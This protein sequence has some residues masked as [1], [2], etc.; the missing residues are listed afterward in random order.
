MDARYRG[1]CGNENP[2]TNGILVVFRGETVVYSKWCVVGCEERRSGGG[3]A[4]A[5]V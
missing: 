2:H 3:M 4:T 1:S 5:S